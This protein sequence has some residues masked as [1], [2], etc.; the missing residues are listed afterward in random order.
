MEA[1]GLE[2]G[3]ICPWHTLQHRSE[4]ETVYCLNNGPLSRYSITK[5]GTLKLLWIGP[6]PANQQG[7]RKSEGK[8]KAASFSLRL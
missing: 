3:I 1:V 5:V 8:G 2:P 6:R 4:V 7:R